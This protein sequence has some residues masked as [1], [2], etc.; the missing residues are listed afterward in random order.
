MERSHAKR[1]HLCVVLLSMLPVAI[2]AVAA[3][4]IR[5]VAVDAIAYR[6]DANVPDAATAPVAGNPKQAPCCAVFAAFL[7]DTRVPAHARP[8]QRI[9]TFISGTCYLG[10]KQQCNAATMRES[11][12]GAIGC[13]LTEKKQ[14]R[15]RIC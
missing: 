5:A 10:A 13:T 15:D 11:G 7:P 9:I 3:D 8:D 4:T 6:P 1:V 2:P 12:D 14:E